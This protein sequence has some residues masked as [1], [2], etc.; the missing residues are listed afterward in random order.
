MIR[1]AGCDLPSCRMSATI[2][3][4]DDAALFLPPEAAKA[5][6]DVPRFEPVASTQESGPNSLDPSM[7]GIKSGEA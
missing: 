5:A 2:P 3:E 1:T 4:E 6:P 7:Q